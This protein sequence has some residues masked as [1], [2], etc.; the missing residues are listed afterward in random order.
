MDTKSVNKENKKL[1]IKFKNDDRDVSSKFIYEHTLPEYLNGFDKPKL[2]YREKLKPKQPLYLLI[3]KPILKQS[4]ILNK[5][6]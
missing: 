3:E 4:D 6:Y 1:D 2:Y 5:Y